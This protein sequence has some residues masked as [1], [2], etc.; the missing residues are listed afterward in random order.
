[1]RN[2][3][4][5]RGIQAA[6]TSGVVIATLAVFFANQH[7]AIWVGLGVAWFAAA[8]FAVVVARNNQK[9]QGS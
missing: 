4:T 1:M 5:D 7:R 6:I 8:S 3:I 2:Y 9:A